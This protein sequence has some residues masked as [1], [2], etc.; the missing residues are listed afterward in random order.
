MNYYELAVK[1]K[2][3]R[4]F[5]NRV[6]A[7]RQLLNFWNYYPDCRKLVPEPKVKL[8][9]YG[10]E[11]AKLLEGCAGYHGLMIE[12][13]HYFAI[14]TEP[15]EYDLE[16]AGYVAEDLVL[17]LTD[18]DLATCWITITDPEEVG[19]RLR[20][21]EGFRTAALVAFGCEKPVRNLTRLDIQ[22][23]SVVTLKKR[24][25]YVAPKLFVDDAVYLERW[26]QQSHVSSLM[27]FDTSF[28]KAIV[29]A[30]CAPSY[31]N[32][33]PYRFILDENRLHLIS[34]PD[35]LTTPDDAR[36][37]LG[38]VMLHLDA[39]MASYSS[40]YGPWTLGAPE[41]QYQLPEGAYIVGS[42]HI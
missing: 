13:P 21:P 32:R 34:I 10:S 20:I 40:M 2:S 1:R 4:A 27:N 3:S 8:R 18:L 39:V 33:Q 29:A 11:T 12:A 24:T 5:K 25:G 15:G 17:K 23:P 30:C 9:V 36:L 31:L 6:A 37:N 26:G 35:E 16:N 41:K 7:E 38:I 42:Y 14:L 28:S 19:K 22:S